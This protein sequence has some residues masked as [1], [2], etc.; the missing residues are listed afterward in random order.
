MRIAFHGSNAASFADGF[1]ALLDR[2]HDIRLLPDD[3]PAADQA[4]YAAAEVIIS[5]KLDPKTPIPGSVRLFHSPG[6]GVNAIDIGLLPAG[7]V[8]CNCFGHEHAIAEYVMAA[9]LLQRIDLPRADAD[10][11]R[12]IWTF[13]ANSPTTVHHEVHGATIGLLGFGHIGRAI[14]D[15]AR[16]FGMRVHAA[17]RSP[18]A[19]GKVDRA[20]SLAELPE[21]MASADFV[22]ASLPLLPETE[23][24]VDAAAIAA[25]RP[26]AVILNV[27]R[28][29][30]IDEI[31]LYEALASRRIAGAVIDTWYQYPPA[32]STPGDGVVTMP[33]RLPFHTLP[34]I[35]MTPHMSGWTTGTIARRRAV[36]AEN[37]NRLDRGEPLVNQVWPVPSSA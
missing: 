3:L 2:P 11:R 30:V 10:L 37:V 15:R 6:A 7:A 14:A 12:G 35:V 33:S 28:G 24:L 19:A 32:D 20:F 18:I 13:W 5:A 16:A 29:G 22:V 34:N 1:A 4:E 23:G 27:G 21:F 8:L 26:D 17:N 9:I 31:A 36:M 25:M